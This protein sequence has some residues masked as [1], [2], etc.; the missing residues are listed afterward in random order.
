M[1]VGVGDG[2]SADADAPVSSRSDRFSPKLMIQGTNIASQEQE[3]RALLE[4]RE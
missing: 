1:I 3:K 4:G 2:D